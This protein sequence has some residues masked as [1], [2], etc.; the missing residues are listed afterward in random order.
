MSEERPAQ[1]APE[2][3][4]SGTAAA[5]SDAAAISPDPERSGAR[6][7]DASTSG[8]SRGT[9]PEDPPRSS[10]R[11]WPIL[12]LAVVLVAA[13]AFAAG[14]FTTFGVASGP[15]DADIGFTRDMQVHHAQAVEMAMVE[16]AATT[17]DDL[18]FTAYDIAVGQSAQGGEMYGWL[19]E[20]GL[21]P[22]GDDPLMSWMSGADHHH[23]ATA[24]STAT[25][26]ELHEAMGMATDDELAELRESAGTT[27]GDCLFVDLMTRHHAGALEMVDAVEDLGS[28]PRVGRVATAM[29]QTQQR[30]IDALRDI[31]DELACG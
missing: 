2:P 10:R 17:N 30:E 7:A 29:R 19:V 23:G 3:A 6:A 31:A 16:Y 13:L 1:D 12:A 22:Y 20:W 4:G 11:L 8:R 21:P 9:E 28:D 27:A 26:A 25:D 15:N 5:P 14:R 18:R 24:E